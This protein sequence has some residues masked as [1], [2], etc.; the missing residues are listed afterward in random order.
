M[1]FSIFTFYLLFK[2][3]LFETIGKKITGA[4]KIETRV[5]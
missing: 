1:T 5:K 3:N 2:K 4:I